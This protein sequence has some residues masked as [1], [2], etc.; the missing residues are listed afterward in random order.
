MFDEI[1][2][3]Q[4]QP[5]AR[6]RRRR[7]A[8]VTAVAALATAALLITMLAPVA[9]AAPAKKHP[10]AE[11]PFKAEI[12]IVKG[13]DSGKDMGCHTIYL[14][15]D[16]GFGDADR[17]KE[18]VEQNK[19]TRAV[20]VLSSHGGS[21]FDALK[22]GRLIR[23]KYFVTFVKA[24]EVC[25]SACAN[26]WIAGSTRYVQEHSKIGF[27]GDYVM[28]THNGAPIKGAKATVSGGGNAVVGAYL[29]W[30]GLSDKA[31][32]ALTDKGPD[33]LLWLTGADQ[34]NELGIKVE[35]LPVQEKT[36]NGALTP[37]SPAL[38]R[39]ELNDKFQPLS[40]AKVERAIP[41]E[42]LSTSKIEETTPSN[43]KPTLTRLTQK[44]D[45][46][47]SFYDQRGSFS[48]SSIDH[49]KGS[50]FYD[51][52]GRFSGSAIRNSDGTTSYFGPDGKFRGS[53]TNTT[54]PR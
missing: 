30:L 14:T 52:D 44:A 11:K 2:A 29:G 49:G 27:H 54:Q 4:K 24:D 13:C 18:A 37:L 16:I 10:A 45:V 41:N 21:S 8:I 50:S 9:N 7:A 48:G 5:R 53:S 51:R 46:S 28:S 19:I 34:L 15:G 23:Q 47:R 3:L 1:F 33:Q 20:V 43:L 39:Q 32:Y 38:V 26:I 35:F 12:S 17:F 31:I 42:L 25:A 22:I 6:Q 36:I 40:V